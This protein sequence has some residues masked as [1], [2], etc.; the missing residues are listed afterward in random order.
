MN[1]WNPYWC[2]K[3]S[4]LHWI[5]RDSRNRFL[6]KKENI[7]TDILENLIKNGNTKNYWRIKKSSRFVLS[8]FDRGISPRLNYPNGKRVFL[9]FV[10]NHEWRPKQSVQR[11]LPEIVLLL[12]A[13]RYYWCYFLLHMNWNK[14]NEKPMIAFMCCEF[15]C[16]SVNGPCLVLLPKWISL[17]LDNFNLGF[18]VALKGSCELG[19]RTDPLIFWETFSEYRFPPSTVGRPFHKFLMMDPKYLTI[20]LK[21]ML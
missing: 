18:S 12:R 17:T 15:Y 3:C 4:L 19:P 11:N 20:F 9:F 6:C 21:R 16:L 13:R 1:P 8:K 5:R 2:T 14:M 7:W 10:G